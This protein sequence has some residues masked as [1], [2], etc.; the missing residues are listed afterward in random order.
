MP[1]PLPGS[2]KADDYDIGP[3]KISIAGASCEMYVS[4]LPYLAMEGGG[5]A[6]EAAKVGSKALCSS[7]RYAMIAH[8]DWERFD[9][10]SEPQREAWGEV[11]EN[12]EK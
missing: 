2:E 1:G 6:D 8:I 11:A 10:S 3:H 9:L 5:R 12:R 7:A 4:P